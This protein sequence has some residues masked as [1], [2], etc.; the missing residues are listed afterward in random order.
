MTIRVVT[1]A[2][3]RTA[4]ILRSA[5]CGSLRGLST[6]RRARGSVAGQIRFPPFPRPRPCHRRA[7]AAARGHG[8]EMPARFRPL[9]RWRACGRLVSASS[10]VRC[11]VDNHEHDCRRGLGNVAQPVRRLGADAAPRRPGRDSPRSKRFLEMKTEP[12]AKFTR[13]VVWFVCTELFLSRDVVDRE[14]CR[15]I[16]DRRRAHLPPHVIRF[17]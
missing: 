9:R 10:V 17:D 3:R 13:D 12:H 6:A 5:P 8:R 15:F 2:A 4:S 14:R 1:L 16:I 11:D 7:R